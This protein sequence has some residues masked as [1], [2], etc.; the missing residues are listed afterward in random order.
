LKHNWTKRPQTLHASKAASWHRR[1]G[2]Q[3][4]TQTA[5]PNALNVWQMRA[6]MLLDLP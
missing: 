2:I 5:S 6:A 3:M 1:I 4:G